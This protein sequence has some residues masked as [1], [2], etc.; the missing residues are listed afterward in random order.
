MSQGI[1]V[2]GS[3]S[4]GALRAAELLAFG[5]EGVG[6]IFELYRDG[7]LEDDDEVAIA[8]GPPEI[9]FRAASEAMINIRSTL[10]K[11][12]L[13]D[14]ISAKSRTILKEIGKELFYPDRNYEFL[15]RSAR[16]RGIPETE[17]TRFQQ[18]LPNGRVN[19]KREDALS[20]LRLMRQRLAQGLNPK[21]VFYSFQQTAMW[22]AACREAANSSSSLCN[23]KPVGSPGR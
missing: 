5:M 15:L 16:D 9:G 21:I 14:I 4:I 8:H 23:N 11:A 20:M 12:E 19:Q 18:W 22:E 3:A 10:R 1:H 6:T 17:L 7:V 13:N 2:F